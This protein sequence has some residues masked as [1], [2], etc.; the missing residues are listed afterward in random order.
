MAEKGSNTSEDPF[1]GGLTEETFV[2]GLMWLLQENNL[3]R[4][5]FGISVQVK[6]PYVY[7]NTTLL[8]LPVFLLSREVTH[9]C[10]FAINLVSNLHH[11]GVKRE[12]DSFDFF[13]AIKGW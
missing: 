8:I 5:S 9:A 3:L 10:S 13:D 12:V 7:L 6:G 2:E 4:L 11:D 1:Q